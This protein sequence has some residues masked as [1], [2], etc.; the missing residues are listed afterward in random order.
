MTYDEKRELKV[1]IDKLPG[2]KLG[3]IVQ[4]IQHREPSSMDS[5]SEEIEIDFES[6]KPS[7]LRALEVYVMTGHDEGGKESELDNEEQG[8]DLEERDSYDVPTGPY[9]LMVKESPELKQDGVVYFEKRENTVTIRQVIMSKDAVRRAMVGFYNCGENHAK[10]ADKALRSLGRIFNVE[11]NYF[12][13]DVAKMG[14]NLPSKVGTDTDSE[15][16]KLPNTFVVEKDEL[17][18]VITS[19]EAKAKLNID[20]VRMFE[21]RHESY[22][23]MT[24]W[25]CSVGSCHSSR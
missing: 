12:V 7:T 4:I 10:L 21:I 13:H 24:A 25:S 2:D 11:D 18:D 16:L 14:V 23:F 6:L 1:G 15:Q 3:K 17:S 8:D 9:D 22:I 5:N 19:L 20:S